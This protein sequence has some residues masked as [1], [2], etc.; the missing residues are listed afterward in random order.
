[1]KIDLKLIYKLKKQ[2]MEKKIIYVILAVII[3]LVFSSWYYFWVK[4]W[5]SEVEKQIEEKFSFNISENN[6]KI[7]KNTWEIFTWTVEKSWT[8]LDLDEK[9][10]KNQEQ[11]EKINF[12]NLPKY[13]LETDS[14]LQ[15]FV[16]STIPF[17]DISYV[18][19]NLEKISSDFVFDT[20]W[21]NQ[22]LVSVANEAL[23]KMAE[24]FF[25]ETWEK[26]SVVSAYRSYEYQVGIK[27]RWCPD[28]LC[29]KAWYSEHQTWLVVDLWSASS[30]KEWKT[31]KKLQKYFS[32][33]NQ[34]A[35]KFWFTNSYQKWVAV[36]WYEIEP[37]HWRYVWVELAT[38]LK[39]KWL[40]FAEFYNIA[41][42]K[43]G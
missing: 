5:V 7:E 36:D 1:M 26:V 21:W 3:A 16:T 27:S 39:Q 41:K 29:A 15:K 13:D 8:T 31:N 17:N 19:Q 2:K 24:K 40:T 32:W 42:N 38:Y 34:N 9:E 10:D 33:L 14:S 11:N 4:K 37:W 30:E 43:N 12:D 18:P 23:Q 22:T 28:N 20:K 6:E 35:H 25:N